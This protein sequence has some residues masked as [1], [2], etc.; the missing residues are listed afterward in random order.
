MVIDAIITAGGSGRRFGGKKQF[1]TLNKIP[2]LRLTADI[3]ATHPRIETVIVT[4]P[5]G[6][7]PAVDEIMQGLDRPY[8]IVTGG[9][10]RQLS[11]FNGIKASTAECVLIHD[12]VRP[13]VTHKLI[14]RVIDG[15]NDSAACIPGIK[16]SDTI[17]EAHDGFVSR[18]VP[19]ED[20]YSI[21]TPQGFRRTTIIEAHQQA[22]RDQYSGATDD[23]ALIEKYG[24]KVR[25]VAGEPDN[26]KIT[27]PEDIRRAEEILKWRT[28]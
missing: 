12:G 15:L 14:S 13:L 2:V 28:E 16:L 25:L 22:G 1:S 5:A 26:I 10:T 4:V 24:G 23:S 3:F 17:K 8:R 18:T 20:L 21:Q 9:A 11:V 6:D 27:L 19:R 7:E